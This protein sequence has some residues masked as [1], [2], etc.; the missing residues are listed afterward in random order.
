MSDYKDLFFDIPC[1]T[2]KHV[3][4]N[5]I[6]YQNQKYPVS[7]IS[8]CGRKYKDHTSQF[9]DVCIAAG[10]P[11]D[12]PYQLNW[13]VKNEK[14]VAGI[15]KSARRKGGKPVCLVVNP[16]KPF[17]RVDNWGKEITI[18]AE[19]INGIIRE[20]R[21]D[22]YFVS[23][24]KTPIAKLEHID[25]NMCGKTTV[26]DL[27]DIASISQ[28]I[29]A[30]IGFALPLAESLEKPALIIFS[31][32]GITCGSAFLEAITPKKVIHKKQLIKSII[33]DESQEEINKIF[34]GL[35]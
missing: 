28:C 31:K 27:I 18:N 9:E 34:R 5:H 25:Q 22:Y 26:S 17:G 24:C 13:T 19:V 12:I 11:T 32:K 1:Y 29:V 33:D 10:V 16:H 3:K 4:T 21:K 8:Y 2:T 20:Y 7:K 23:V 15:R 14:L 6:E 30:Q 35:I